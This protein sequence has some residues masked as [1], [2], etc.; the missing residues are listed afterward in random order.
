MLVRCGEFD[1]EIAEGPSLTREECVPFV[2]NRTDEGPFLWKIGRRGD[3]HLDGSRCLAHRS[4]PTPAVVPY[5]WP[6]RAAVRARRVPGRY[7]APSP[8]ARLPVRFIT[9]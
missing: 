3:H 5:P 9:S 8:A 2:D 1:R 7:G 4:P 6:P